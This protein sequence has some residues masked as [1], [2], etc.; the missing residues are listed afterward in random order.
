MMTKIVFIVLLFGGY[1]LSVA[2]AACPTG[3][4]PILPLPP[5]GQQSQGIIEY[6]IWRTNLLQSFYMF[7]SK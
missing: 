7:V 5:R 6:Y 2:K 1:Y 4:S 3:W